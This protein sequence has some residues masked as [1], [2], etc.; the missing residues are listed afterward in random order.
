MNRPLA[1]R[2]GALSTEA[3]LKSFLGIG[4]KTLYDVTSYPFE[5][6]WAAKK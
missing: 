2:T 5:Q 3:A 1:K 6:M 4:N